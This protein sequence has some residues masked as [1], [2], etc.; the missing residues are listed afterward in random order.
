MAGGFISETQIYKAIA[1]SNYGNGPMVKAVLLGRS[2]I[3]AVMKSSYFAQ[4][5]KEGRL[6]RTFADRYGTT[7]DKFFVATPE[8]RQKYGDRFSEIPWEAIGLYTY[9]TERVGVGL[10]QLLA[11]SR[12]FKLNLISRKELMALTERANKVTG[13][14]LAE[15]AEVDEM[16]RILSD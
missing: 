14:P 12:K 13:I 8:L 9:L 6:A 10:K 1:M 3:T 4:L 2:P 15:E 7:P 11:G 16:E 5:A